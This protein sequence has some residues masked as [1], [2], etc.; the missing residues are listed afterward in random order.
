MASLRHW[1][2][3]FEDV[4]MEHTTVSSTVL[5]LLPTS[6]Q[7]R[8]P[9]LRSVQKSMQTCQTSVT[10]RAS[11]REPVTPTPTPRGSPKKQSLITDS[12]SRISCAS[13]LLDDEAL[14]SSPPSP[15]SGVHWR[16]ALQG[17]SLLSVAPD[18][19]RQPL[20]SAEFERKAFLD[21]AEYILKALPADLS[22]LEL[23]RLRTSTPRALVL[24]R[25]GCPQG[26]NTSMPSAQCHWPCGHAAASSSSARP[27]RSLLHRWVQA[28][29]V[30]MFI[31]AHLALPYVVLLARLAA[32]AEREYNISHNL[33]SAGWGLV[34]SIGAQGVKAT[35][36]L[37]GIGD[38]RVGQAIAE[39]V[40]WTVEGVSGGLSEGVR[41][42]MVIMGASRQ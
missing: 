7:S 6:L 4:K 3:V 23:D 42:G 10:N 24:G 17:L 14:D 39:A 9:P 36:T 16:Y 15:P 32:R 19:A 5:S 11:S 2:P 20:A 18:E 22:P 38:G 29:V 34:H 31:L 37:C 40:A 1:T 21:G 30:Q 28:A 25:Q 41:Q 12:P 26:C 35:G 13:T 33:A 8:L 27:R